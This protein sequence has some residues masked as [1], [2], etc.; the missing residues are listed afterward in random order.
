MK[1]LAVA[2]CIVGLLSSEVCRGE[3]QTNPPATIP[4]SEAKKYIGEQKTVTG[5][6]AEVNKAEKLVRLNFDKPFPRQSFTVVIFGATT[7]QFSELDALQG[8]VIEVTGKIA[9]Y[10]ERAQIVLTS[11]NQLRVIQEAP[12]AK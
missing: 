6:V 3:A 8:K 11:T 1:V 10:R 7:N 4:A 12:D 5:K 2:S 9:E